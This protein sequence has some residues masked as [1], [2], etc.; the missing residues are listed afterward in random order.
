LLIKSDPATVQ[1]RYAEQAT[2]DLEENRREQRE[3]TSRL[4]VLRQEE[5]LLLDILSLAGR[6]TP[7]SLDEYVPQQAR[8]SSAPLSHGSSADAPA[9]APE[10]TLSA[11]GRALPE[12][13]E[14]KSGTTSSDRK[15]GRAA[16]R[17][18]LLGELLLDILKAHEEP[19]LAKELRDE[20]LEAHPE[21]RPTPQVVRN[22]LEALVAKGRIERRK[23]K[24]SVMYTMVESDGDGASEA[25]ARAAIS[26]E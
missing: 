17:Q 11:D 23:Q 5:A 4:E 16:G 13:T 3:L 25:A 26:T 8:G 21:R 14:Q 24:R 22:T 9:P 18:P 2:V 19:R 20:L 1:S 15:P 12:A 6:S 7:P 10:D